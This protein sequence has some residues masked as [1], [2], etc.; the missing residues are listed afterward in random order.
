MN[1]DLRLHNTEGLKPLHRSTTRPE[2]IRENIGAG[3]GSDSKRVFKDAPFS[4]FFKEAMGTVAATDQADKLSN[5]GLM[6]GELDNLHT[7]TIAAE[8]ADLMLNLTLQVRNKMVEAY[9][10]VMRMQM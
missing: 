8:E 2:D 1:V 4:E 7:A 6:T 10:E 3:V 9:Q 5:I